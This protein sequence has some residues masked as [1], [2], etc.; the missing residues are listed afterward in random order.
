MWAKPHPKDF[1]PVT[2]FRLHNS[3]C[4]EHCFYPQVQSPSPQQLRKLPKVISWPGIEL[5]SSPGAEPVG[6][7]TLLI[8]TVLSCLLREGLS[9]LDTFGKAAAPLQ[10]LCHSP[11]LTSVPPSPW[12]SDSESLPGF[13]FLSLWLVLL[14]ASGRPLPH[15][16]H[17]FHSFRKTGTLSRM[18]A[19]RESF[20][21]LSTSPAQPSETSCPLTSGVQG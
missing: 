20:K 9:S 4:C 1:I 17:K 7:G 21:C 19:G 10:P 11:A 18:G 2:L 16:V 6:P 12:A 14:V 3:P 8:T 5:A 15:S 13:L